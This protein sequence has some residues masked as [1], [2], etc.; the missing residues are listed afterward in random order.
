MRLTWALLALLEAAVAIDSYGAVALGN[1]VNNVGCAGYY[2]ALGVSTSPANSFFDPTS[3]VTGVSVAAIGAQG[4]T[5]G[6]IAAARVDVAG[7]KFKTPADTSDGGSGALSFY[8]GYLGVAGV[9]NNS[10][11][12]GAVAG[13]LAEV[14]SVLTSINVW[15]DNDNAVGFKWD[16]TQTDVTKKWDI[17]DNAAGETNGYDTLDAKGS[18]DLTNLTWTPISHTKVQ[19]NTQVGLTNTPDTCEI[20]SLT[21]SGSI[22]ASTVITVTARIASQPVLINGNRHGPDRI[23]FDV[24]VQYPW[25]AMSARLYNSAKAK[26]ALISLAA[27]KSG[28][29]VGTAVKRDDTSDSLVFASGGNFMAYYAYKPTCTVDGTD[30]AVTTQVVTGQ[31]ILDF[32]CTGA[33]CAGLLGLGGGLTNLVAISLKAK[34]A[35]LGAFGWKASIAFHALGTTYMPADVLWDPETGATPTT[36]GTNSAAFAAPSLLFLLAIFLF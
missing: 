32:D 5:N 36:M 6:T 9:W 28:A 11:Q 23:K 14:V 3:N 7:I 26:V 21:T 20:H 31:Q 24:R 33:P 27:G 12:T 10:T 25:A 17:F 4:A 22:A 34:V 2:R 29:F 1:C 35:W 15:Y 8:F 30:A 18:I 16:I 13:A 19:C